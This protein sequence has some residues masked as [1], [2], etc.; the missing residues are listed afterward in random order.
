MLAKAVAK[1]SG[2][3]M[4]DIQASD[5]Y[6]MYVGQGEKNV[7]AVFS[8]AR[9]LSP[10]VV[11]IDEVDSLM[12]KRGS[13]HSSKSHRE[14]INQFM[15]EWDGLSSDNTGVIVMAATNRP[16]DLDDA[17]LRRMPRRILGNN[18]CY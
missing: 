1:E 9:K 17:V 13:D 7:R 8:L 6:D 15:V 12:S 5:V 10:C 4:L 18:C 14:I 2:S 3:R 11:F 16:F